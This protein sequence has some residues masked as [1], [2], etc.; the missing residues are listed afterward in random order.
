MPD[1]AAEAQATLGLAQV[2]Q[3]R[4]E[5]DAAI[6]KAKRAAELYRKLG[7]K[8]D[9]ANALSLS[10]RSLRALQRE[11]EAGAAFT[12]AIAAIEEV[13]GRVAGGDV[14]RETFFAQQIAPYHEMISLL[15]RQNKAADAL[16]MAER[17]SAR[18][19]LDITGGG[20]TNLAAVLT[21]PEQ[22][23]QRDL[24]IKLAGA[25]REL[26]RLRTAEKSDAG[27]ISRAET[28]LRETQRAREEFD[29]LSA[30]AHPE[31]RRAALPAPLVATG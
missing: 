25:E 28:T 4:G 30:T 24:E 19:L 12:E 15:V 27:A 1:V 9:L 8:V 13:R 3:A 17:A 23:S 5:N 16:A 31:L 22:Q 14:E 2:A 21:P 10:G 20:R 6:E 11:E 7:Q 29:T 26:A 18:V